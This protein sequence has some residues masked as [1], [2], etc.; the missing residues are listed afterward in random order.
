MLR[1]SHQFAEARRA[2]AL[3]YFPLGES[4]FK[5]GSGVG[6]VSHLRIRHYVTVL[7][8]AKTRN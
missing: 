3:G 8:P 7:S 5:P 2:L 6:W 4:H 1:L